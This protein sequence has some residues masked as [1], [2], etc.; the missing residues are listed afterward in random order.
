MPDGSVRPLVDV[1][2][3]PGSWINA[4]NQAVEADSRSRAKGHGDFDDDPDTLTSVL[5]RI[6]STTDLSSVTQYPKGGM[7]SSTA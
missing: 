7:P 3:G 2:G 1:I 6:L 5:L 4:P